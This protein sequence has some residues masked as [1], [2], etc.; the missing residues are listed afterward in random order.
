MKKINLLKFTSDEWKPMW[1]IEANV[2]LSMDC[3]LFDET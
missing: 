1:M 2:M 3:K